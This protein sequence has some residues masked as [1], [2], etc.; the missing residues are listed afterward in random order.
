MPARLALSLCLISMVAAACSSKAGEVPEGYPTYDPFLPL[1]SGGTA[2]TGYQ[3]P[4]ARPTRTAGPT[5][6]RAPLKILIPTHNPDAPL[7]TPTPDLPRTLPTPRKAADQYVVQ[8]GDTLGSVAQAYGI[9]VAEL[10]QQN[11]LTDSSVL[12]IGQTLNIPVGSLA[13]PGSAFKV[14]PDSELVYG[15]ASA[16]FD[17][18]AFAQSQ[19]GFLSTYTEDVNEETLTGAQVVDL[20][21]Q[22]F[23][24]NPR[25]LLALLEYRSRWVTSTKPAA[26][27][28]EYPLG[29]VE[30]NHTGL[31]HQ[32]SW[33]ANELS[34]G[35]YLWRINAIGQW[36]LGDG[37]IV[38]VDP[39]INAGTAGVQAMFSILD[40]RQTWDT[41]VTAYGLFQTYFFMFGNP[42]DRALE[43]LLPANLSQP[44]M[45]WP[46][47]P[48]SRWAF[49]GGPHEAWTSGTAW[50]ALDFAPSDV[51]G[52]AMSEEWV[53]AVANG[54]IVRAADGAVI[55]DLDGDA[56]EQ[57]GWDV[58]YMHMAAQDRVQAGAYVLTG[59]RIG[60][61]SCE[62]G[63]ANA[64][65]LHLARKY[66]GEW[67]P[68]DGPL[69]F[70]LSGWKSSG[71][72]IE[73]DG[74]LKRGA[75]TLEAAEG[76]TDHNQIAP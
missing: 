3:T 67:I 54:F 13:A 20:V 2:V 70:V 10:E 19:N 43:P 58:L 6:T 52:C 22:S 75:A 46:F 50:A 51:S 74:F 23:S 24:V 28:L 1:Q 44:R 68:A 47:S 53:T 17:V 4:A 27:T 33:A 40:D 7:V 42:F 8:A 11:N 76:I 39:S 36:V 49:T 9:S 57:T 15:P 34:R 26:S 59:D 35:F 41:D 45:D 30:P 66:N 55:E 72:G 64:A 61:P 5:P 14:I 32:L 63:V 37:S 18:S 62:G 69:P 31:Y 38:P 65:H 12:S 60:H 21:A 56:Y 16:Q 25:L 71:D 73:Y 48:D 29:F